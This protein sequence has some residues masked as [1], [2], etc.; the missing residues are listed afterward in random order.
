MMYAL[1]RYSMWKGQF[2]EGLIGPDF[3]EAFVKM[4]V[5]LREIFRTPA[6]SHLSSKI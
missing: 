6:G 1:K 4:I 2:Q 3:S 5:K